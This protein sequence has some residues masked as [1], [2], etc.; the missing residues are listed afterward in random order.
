[1]AEEHDT[2]WPLRPWI[3]AGLLALGGLLVHFASDGGMAE[4]VPWRMALTALAFFG[5][6]AAAFS[7]ERGKYVE[8][9]I[10]AG[11]VGLVMAGIAWRVTSAGSRYSDEQFW[12]G[13]GVVSV[14]LALPLFQANFHR[15]RFATPYPEVHAEAWNDALCGAGAL[16]FTGVS[17]ALLF[18]LDQ[19]FQLVGI[20]VI[21]TLTREDW[22][23]WTFSGAAFG[24]GL[25]TLR[26][27]LKILGTLQSV[28]MLVLSILALPLAAGLIVFLVALLAT[29]GTALWNATDSAT[30]VLLACAIGAF[31]LGNAILRDSDAEMS[32]NRVLRYAA[33]ALCLSILPLTVFAAISMG[34]RISQH[35]L[36]PERLWGL[37]AVAVACA[38]GLA[39]LVAVI[40]GRKAGW[41]ARVR[42]ANLH[43][44]AAT[45]VVALILALPIVDFGA[46]SA[47]NQVARLEAGKV[48][49]KD[50]DYAALRWDFGDSGRKALSTLSRSGN[51]TVAELART[52][53]AQNERSYRYDSAPNKT[54]TDFAL[55]VQPE[56]P[57]LRKQVLD[58]LVANPYR[59]E[60]TCFAL[61]RATEATG[62]RRVVLIEGKGWLMLRLPEAAGSE[63][64]GMR[65]VVQFAPTSEE[66]AELKP[67]SKVE[68]RAISR[69]YVV[70]DGK[71]MGQPLD[72]LEGT[73]P[74]R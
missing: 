17:W 25:G 50:F 60:E 56:D 8:P 26:N 19:L 10:F 46:I 34:A 62:Q 2:D 43:L 68:V 57:V 16:A 71:P 51:P 59:C 73:P 12:I 23:G 14:T 24:A 22:F 74:P 54:R 53:L 3:L 5:F 48:S 13:A 72:E 28:A 27:Q 30:P 67:D 65:D 47:K 39:Y 61:E 6:V 11:L 29:G 66:M 32:G 1:M 55:R 70:V 15:R 64:S 33:L 58:Y 40:R 41:K 7:L 42:D 52:S 18:I 38:F 37:I 44:A 69:P 31:G 20:H 9:A 63:T 35:G 49:A 45:C 21:E 4:T 36:S